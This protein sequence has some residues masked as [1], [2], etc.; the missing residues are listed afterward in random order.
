MGTHPQ[1]ARRSRPRARCREVSSSRLRR[2]ARLGRSLDGQE[3]LVPEA[4]QEPPQ[5]KERLDARAIEALRA[6]P[7][8]L[9][10]PG[11]TKDAQVLGDRR[12]AHLEVLRDL[13]RSA[14]LAPDETDDLLPPRF[15]DGLERES[16]PDDRKRTVTY[17]SSYR[18]RRSFLR[19]AAGRPSCG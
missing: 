6:H 9:H 19:K 11:L 12:P 4:V 7:P 1:A 13:A 8:L 18:C 15:R 10:E 2:R 17:P 3:A 14:L 5:L 16:H